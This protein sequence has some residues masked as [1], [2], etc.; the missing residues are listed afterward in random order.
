[1]KIKL[2]TIKP[3]HDLIVEN[4]NGIIPSYDP[5]FKY[6][7]RKTIMNKSTATLKERLTGWK[8]WDG[9]TYELGVCLGLWS[10]YG[11]PP[12]YDA[13][14]GN[15]GIIWSNNPLGSA[16]SSFLDK[17]VEVG[18]LERRE[19]PDIGYRWNASYIED[20]GCSKCRGICIPQNHA[21]WDPTQEGHG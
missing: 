16:L 1:M 6:K 13:W 15:K 2:L 3:N 4:A 17:L 12:G 20:S 5:N 21:G 7:R 10:D 19:E 9:A 11:A 8:D 18:M 14:H